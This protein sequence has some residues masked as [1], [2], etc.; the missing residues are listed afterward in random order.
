MVAT[1]GQNI[2]RRSV[3]GDLLVKSTARNPNN[4]ILR[5][6]DKNYTYREFNNIVNRCAY[7]LSSLGIKKGDKAA[8]LSHNCDYYLFYSWALLKIGAVMTPINW[9][10]KDREIKDIVIHSESVFFLVEDILVPEVMKIKDDL[11]GVKNFGYIKLSDIDVPGNWLNFTDLCSEENPDDEPEAILYD[12]DPA[13]LLYTSGT[14]AAPKGVILSHGGY[15]STYAAAPLDLQIVPG[16][17]MLLGAPLFH[18]AATYLSFAQIAMGNLLVLEYIPDM[19]EVL[20]LTDEERITH[21]SWPTTVYMNLPNVPGFEN[22]D[23]TSLR[24]CAVWGALVPPA[25]LKMWK[26]ISPGIIY[27]HGWGQTEVNAM[28]AMNIGKEFENNP[29]SVGKPMTGIEIKIFDMD[30]KELPSGE[31]GEIVLR[32]KSVMTGYFKEDEKTSQTL[33][34]GWHHTGD[35]GKFDEKGYL[36]FIDRLKDMIKTGGENVASADVEATLFEHPKILEVAVI[37]LPDDVWGEAITAVI[38]LKPD[39]EAEEK[40]IISWAKQ[41]MAAYKVPKKIIFMDEIPKNPSGKLL[42]KELRKLHL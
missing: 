28:G 12:G 29:E 24:V 35:L 18:I 38:T 8:I 37:G 9:M 27:T 4:R 23:L 30:D 33:R 42:K 22:Y 7:G 41:N 13:I 40:E 6:R 15:F 21:W 16:D 25:L 34:G 2:L 10:L 5:F 3:V 26:K 32:G 19:K 14:E 31:V 36:Y 17:I 39:T 1:L 11:K 20:E